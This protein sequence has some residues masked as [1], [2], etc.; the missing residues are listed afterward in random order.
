MHKMNAVEKVTGKR[1]R[2]LFKRKCETFAISTELFSA[3]S[4]NS[5]F[6]SA[7]WALEFFLRKEK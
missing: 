2:N 4:L 5:N 6:L 3:S 7:H 1:R